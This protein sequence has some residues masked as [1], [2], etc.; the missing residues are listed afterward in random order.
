MNVI[1]MVCDTFRADHLGCYGNDWIETP[2]LD[3]LSAEGVTFSQC[4]GDGLPTI[5]MRRVFFTGNSILPEGKWKPLNPGD[6]TVAEI[7]NP[8]GVKTGLI[9]DCPHF[10]KPD[11]NFHRAFDSWEWVRGQEADKWKSGPRDAVDPARHV[12]EHMRS[13][14][15]DSLARQYLMNTRHWQSEDDYFCAQTCRRAMKWL[16]HNAADR[17]FLL[18]LEMFDP[19]EPWDPPLR[20][21]RKYHDEFPFDRPLFG[22]GVRRQDVRQE[23]LP[24][25][26]ALYAGEVTFVDRWIGRLLEKL[27]DLGLRDDTV[28]IFTTD[29][30]THLGEEGCIQKTPGLLNSAVAQLPL[31]IRHPDRQFA[32]NR[33]DSLVS[34]MDVA[35]TILSLLGV[36]DVPAMDG[37]DL[38]PLAAGE[39][40]SIRDRVFIGFGQFGAVRDA[41]W[42]YFQNV[43]GGEAGRG[44]ALYDLAN[45]PD[46]TTNVGDQHPEVV[47]ER[48]E[49][50]A[51]RFGVEL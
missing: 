10:F 5:P 16:E 45:D 20:Y 27:D 40:A 51:E 28:I 8:K 35:P 19:H 25:I 6:V 17:P 12:P 24:W 3:Q 37:M 9:I 30:G 29:H 26:R 13:E 23:D 48:K 39:V 32:G 41:Q 43:K 21:A 1:M 4:Y 31:I 49:L 46:E 34:G 14:P 42:H 2:N 50:L 18:W 44:P 38:W 7:A 15:Y 33:V 11:L 47:A 36:S 22:Y